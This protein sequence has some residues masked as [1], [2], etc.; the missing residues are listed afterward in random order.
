MHFQEGSDRIA[1]HYRIPQNGEHLLASTQTNALGGGCYHMHPLQ[2]NAEPIGM[3]RPFDAVNFLTKGLV[4]VIIRIQLSSIR[5]CAKYTA[6]DAD[7]NF[8]PSNS[9]G[10]L[11]A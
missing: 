7:T 5:Q 9:Q 3:A 8:P 6:S 2:N 11:T 10:K 1:R 4:L